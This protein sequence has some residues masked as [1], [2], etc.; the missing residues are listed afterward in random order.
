[1][2]SGWMYVVLKTTQPNAANNNQ[3]NQYGN[4]DDDTIREVSTRDDENAT[5]TCNR[6]N[7]AKCLR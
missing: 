7:Q 6:E 2:L 5:H 4:G 3:Q 1:M